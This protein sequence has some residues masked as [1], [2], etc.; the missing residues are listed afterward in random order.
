MKV[1]LICLPTDQSAPLDR[2]A[3]EAE[4]RGFDSLYQGDHTHIPARRTSPFIA[5]GDL[6]DDYARLVDPIVGLTAAASATERIEVGTCVFLLAQRDPIATAKQLASL[7]H[8]SGGRVVLGIG[9]G[10]NR[11]EAADHGV[12]WDTRRARTR[13]YVAAMRA[14]WTEEKASYQ[15]QFVDFEEAWMW[16]KPVR[17]PPVIL[18]AGATER[19]FAEV[20][21]WSDGWL[22]V[23][24]LGHTPDDVVALR[25]RAEERGRDPAS[26]RVIVDGLA[27]DPAA[28]EPW[29]A[30]GVDEVLVHVPTAP[31]DAACRYLDSAVSVRDRY[32]GPA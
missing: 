10:W 16:P 21:D 6:P 31:L 28:V 29:V 1:G 18:G 32:G 15:G 13:E 23:P 11:E 24:A 25:R 19:T 26:L 27:P 20:I 3:A 30:M 4:A 2:L 17:V 22:P 14:L 12:A 9:F 5:G 7:D 8:Y